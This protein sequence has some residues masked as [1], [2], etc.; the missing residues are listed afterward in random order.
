MNKK[1]PKYESLKSRLIKMSR[2]AESGDTHEAD[3]ARIA[4]E[5]ICDQ[6]GINMEDVLSDEV[7]SKWYEF[8]IGRSS[9]MLSLFCQCHGYVTGKRSMEYRRLPHS[10]IVEVCLT[11]F[12]YAELKSMFEWHRSNYKAEREKIESTLFD[13]Y[14]HKHNLFRNRNENEEDSNEGESELTPEMLER[15]KRIIYMKQA[16]SDTHYHKMIEQ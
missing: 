9:K 2:L 16:L 7:E 1:D 14:I 15:I 8:N 10:A 6:Y 13:A 11:P 5:R 12:E 4:I 3:A